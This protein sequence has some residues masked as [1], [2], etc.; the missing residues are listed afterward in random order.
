MTDFARSAEIWLGTPF[1]HE[2]DV[3][4][5]G[6]DCAMLVVRV[7]NLPLDPR[8]YPRGGHLRDTRYL[9]LVAP[10]FTAA[11][12]PPQP[13][14]LVVFWANGFPT[15]GAIVTEWPWIIHA[16]PEAGVIL[17]RADTG[18]LSEVA[19]TILRRRGGL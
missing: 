12:G 15:H 13:G 5:V 10:Y 8:P 2:A 14:D 18:H 4:G 17:G 11:T 1:H 19:A 9:D 16:H 7:Y 3:P 6:V